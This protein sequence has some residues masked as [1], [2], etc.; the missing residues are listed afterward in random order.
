MKDLK[1]GKYKIIIFRLYGCISWKQTKSGNYLIFD[2][3]QISSVDKRIPFSFTCCISL[4]CLCIF[5][6]FETAPHSF[7]VLH[8]LTIL[9]IIDQLF[10]IISVHLGVPVR[11]KLCII[12]WNISEMVLFSHCILILSDAH[13]FPLFCYW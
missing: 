9:K 12:G 8:T 11:F 2:P 6:Q 4:S 7:L 5:L 10:H 1:R 3:V 13:V